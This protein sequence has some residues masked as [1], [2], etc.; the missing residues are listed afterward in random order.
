[1]SALFGALG[2]AIGAFGAHAL[3]AHISPEDMQVFKTAGQYHL[4]HVLAALAVYILSFHLGKK[5]LI[6][7]WLF[8][9]GIILFSGSLYALV[10]TQQHWLGIIT[11]L[12]GICFIVG[13]LV[14]AYQFH[15]YSRRH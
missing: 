1:M 4:G 8:I 5:V 15:T 2:V 6:A 11:P 14:L 7:G 9:F 13:W 12:G 3:K 10:I